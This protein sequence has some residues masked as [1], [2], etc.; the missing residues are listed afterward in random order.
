MGKN[1]P[2]DAPQL[3]WQGAMSPP[4]I[5]GKQIDLLLPVPHIWEATKLLLEG[6]SRM[7]EVVDAFRM[8]RPI[9]G[10]VFEEDGF[11]VTAHHNTHVGAPRPG[12]PWESFSY[13]FEADGQSIVYSGDIG[14]P[15][16]VTPLIE[17]GCDMLLMECGHHSVE[18]VC[19]YGKRTLDRKSRMA[20]LHHGRAVVAAPPGEL[21]KG[22]AILGERA[23]YATE[24]MSLFL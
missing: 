23:F 9:D 21:R 24:G 5:A 10:V 7:Q 2:L 19:E 17:Q 11:R 18:E 6:N 16:D 13:R 8:R 3:T 4:P 14:R 1:I 20:L 12:Q 15:E 22:K